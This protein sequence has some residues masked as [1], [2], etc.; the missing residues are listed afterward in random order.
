MI[1]R[2]DFRPFIKLFLVGLFVITGIN[3]CTLGTTDPDPVPQTKVL[4][5]ELYPDTVAVGD[6]V[7][8]HVSIEDSLDTR[9]RFYWGFPEEEQIPVNGTI[10]S[11]KI[12][13]ITK[14]TSQI[15]GE[16]KTAN[17][18]VRIDNGSIDSL[19]VT[20]LFEIPILN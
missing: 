19:S 2:N 5:I 12:K 3:N 1:E 13:W 18:G 17:T 9:F 6:T 7:L 20:E 14:S 4:S 10:Y 8:I 16:V 15:S 11:N